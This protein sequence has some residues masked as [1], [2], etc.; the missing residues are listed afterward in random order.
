MLQLLWFKVDVDVVAQHCQ[1]QFEAAHH[2]RRFPGSNGKLSSTDV[3]LCLF[4][5]RLSQ[6]APA[7]LTRLA[8]SDLACVSGLR[9]S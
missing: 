5:P 3:K 8:L 7:P 9:H 4:G 1:A 6:I 2:R